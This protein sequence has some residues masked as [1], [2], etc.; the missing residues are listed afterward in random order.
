[1]IRLL[2]LAFPALFCMSF[3]AR[4]CP[5]I[6]YEGTELH[7]S[8]TDLWSSESFSVVAGGD[9]WA[10]NGC[11]IQPRNASQANGYFTRAPDFELRYYKN[12]DYSLVFRVASSCDSALLINTGAGN[13]YYDD[14]DDG[15]LDPRITLTRPSDGWYD[16]WVGTID[17][18][19]CDAA[20]ILE[21]FN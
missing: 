16:I 3:A 13:W 5:D 9:S 6:G 7:L 2:M 19:N 14:D 15:N 12:A 18:Y 21:T 11:G 10:G 20:L 17:N 8:S 4:A 1:M